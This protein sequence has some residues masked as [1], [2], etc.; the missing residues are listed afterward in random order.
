MAAPSH[1]FICYSSAD[2]RD[3]ALRLAAALEG[4]DPAFGVWF[5][6]YEKQRN[7]LRPGE[8]WDDQISEGIRTCE[9]L[10][11]VMTVDST[12]SNSE[13]KREWTRALRYKKPVIPIWAHRGAEMP[14]RLEPREGIEGSLDEVVKRLRSKKAAD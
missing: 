14:F 8:D 7:R 3:F 9:N 2:G 10:L 1:S 13:C 12:R 6:V 11:F 5:D 4:G